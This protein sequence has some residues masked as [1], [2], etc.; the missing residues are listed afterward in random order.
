M[1]LRLMFVSPVLVTRI[2]PL[3]IMVAVEVVWRDVLDGG[4]D[5]G[6]DIVADA[7]CPR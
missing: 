7:G 1:S 4:S 5:D 3:V 6:D 2:F